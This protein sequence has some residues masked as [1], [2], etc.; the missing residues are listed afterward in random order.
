[1]HAYI[2]Q[3]RFAVERFLSAAEGTPCNH[4]HCPSKRK[5]LTTKTFK[6]RALPL[7]S[8]WKRE[9]SEAITTENEI[10]AKT[11]RV[12]GSQVGGKGART[13]KRAGGGSKENERKERGERAMEGRQ[14]QHSGK[15]RGRKGRALA[16][17]VAQ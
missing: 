6:N 4:F 11:Q 17:E 14:S 2:L 3:K 8:K 9:C 10:I 15:G 12:T 5:T 13:R 7:L 16:A 1:M